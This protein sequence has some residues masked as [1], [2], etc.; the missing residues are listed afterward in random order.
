VTLS[1]STGP[2][3]AR[4]P[5]V[6]GLTARQ[7]T[8]KLGGAGFRVEPEERFSDDINA[9]RAIGTR[10]DGGTRLEQDKTVTL[11]ISKGANLVEVPSVLE[12]D[13]DEAQSEIEQAGLIANVETEDSEV[14]EGTVIAQDPGAGGA[15]PKGSQVTI[16]VST[17]AGAVVVESVIGDTQQAGRATLRAQAL[18][19]SVQKQDVTDP[20]DDGVIIEQAP[21]G[22]SRVPRGTTVTIVVGHLVEPDTEV[23]GE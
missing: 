9:G 3:T 15:V 10:P 23:P 22:G 13:Q 11:L 12:L 19:V 21:S 2:G 6:A 17:G 5:D 16:T 18:K 8:R 4:V 7:A 20:D 14:P 1:V